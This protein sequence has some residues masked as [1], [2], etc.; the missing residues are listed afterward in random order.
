M[1]FWG[2]LTIPAVA[3][4]LL[5]AGAAFSR[6]GAPAGRGLLGLI[7]LAGSLCLGLLAYAVVGGVAWWSG[8]FDAA[9]ALLIPFLAALWMIF[10]SRFGQGEGSPSHTAILSVAALSGAALLAIWRIQSGVMAWS[11]G[12]GAGPLLELDSMPERATT[13]FVLLGGALG[14]VR[15]QALWEAARCEGKVRLRRAVLGPLI[16]SLVLFLLGSQALLYG[17]ASVRILAMASL[18]LSAACLF[19]LPLLR[20]PGEGEAALPPW[21]H[22][23]PS[24]LV[25]IGLGT[26]LVAL[27]VLGQAVHRY[28]PEEEFIWFHWGGTILLSFFASLWLIPGLRDSLRRWFSPAQAS[29]GDPRWEWARVNQA[30]VPVESPVELAAKVSSL[31]EDL[32]GR[33]GVALWLTDPAG[34]Q[35]LPVGEADRGLPPLAVKNPLVAA[36]RG[37]SRVLNLSRPPDRLSGLPPYVENQELVDRLGFKVFVGLRVGDEALGMLGLAPKGQHLGSETEATLENLGAQLSNVVWG[38]TLAERLARTRAG[39]SF[40]RLGSFV[41]HDLKNAVGV[42][43]GA[44]GNA[45]A[46]MDDPRFRDDLVATLEATTARMEGTLHRLRGGM[47]GSPVIQPVDLAASFQRLQRE[48]MPLAEKA[49]VK[50]VL[51]APAGMAFRSDPERLETILH[52]L[53]RNAIEASPAGGAVV[54]GAG[55]SSEAPEGKDR[56]AGK[57]PAGREVRIAVTDQGTKADLE[58]V[59]RC[60]HQPLPSQKPEGWGIGLYQ[61]NLLAESL[62]GSLQAEPGKAGGLRVTL[63]LPAEGDLRDLGEPRK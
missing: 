10:V 53:L 8:L 60:F 47:A 50:V 44:V 20:R 25:L 39:E 32:L 37:E 35:M 7:A 63:A 30:L 43:R 27:A 46:H 3:A 26:F 4:L 49:G 23:G 19:P 28:L 36:V 34:D 57:D 5:L 6:R 38:M 18:I 33:A 22:R 1:N 45:R 40:H 42:L 15:L 41:L 11:D 51:E 56:P 12:G 29:P 2:W 21:V 16:A 24:S 14:V 55:M 54:L 9:A 58:R 13:G 52:N 62:G 48:L 59:R 31:V 61:S 17:R